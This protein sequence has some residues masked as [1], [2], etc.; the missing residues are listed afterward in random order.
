MPP[1]LNGALRIDVDGGVVVYPRGKGK[2]FVAMSWTLDPKLSVP[3]WLLNFVTRSG[4]EGD[5]F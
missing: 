2:S 5:F 3:A 4:R 1:P